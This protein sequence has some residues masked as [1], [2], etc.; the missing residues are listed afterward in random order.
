[1]EMVVRE[2]QYKLKM[3]SS[4]GVNAHGEPSV[5]TFQSNRIRYQ[6]RAF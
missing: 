1:M 6:T 5:K 2:I 4:E 3:K